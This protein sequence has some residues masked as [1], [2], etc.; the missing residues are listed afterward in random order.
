MS[1]KQ[2]KELFVEFCLSKQE[3]IF[4][5]EPLNTKHHGQFEAFK[6]GLSLG[7]KA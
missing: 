1:E 3:K 4:V 5:S 6:I 7:E 2:L